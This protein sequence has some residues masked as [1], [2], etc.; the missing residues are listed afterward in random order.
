MFVLLVCTLTGRG[1]IREVW[2]RRE[3]KEGK[4][5]DGGDVERNNLIYKGKFICSCSEE[6]R[7][8]I[9]NNIH[10]HFRYLF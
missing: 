9:T 2:L 7:K 10:I 8:V 4:R 1:D 6:Q 5:K 3:G